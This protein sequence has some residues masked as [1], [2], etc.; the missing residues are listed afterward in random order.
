VG[1]DY[2]LVNSSFEWFPGV[3]LYHS[4]DLVHWKQIGAVL[5]RPSNL[6]L[7]GVECSGGIYAPTLRYHDGVFYMITTLNGSHA[8]SGNFIVTAQRPEG[9]WSDPHWIAGAEGIDPS[10]FFDDD[11]RAYYCGNGRPEHL[12]SEKHR[13]IW[14]RELDLKTWSLVGPRGVLDSAEYF[15]SG[16]LGPVNNFEGPHLYKKDGH[17]YLML[18]HGGTSKNHAISIWRGDHPLGPFTVADPANPIV[19]HRG[20]HP[21]GLT[22]TGHGDLLQDARG[23]WWMALLGVR[24]DTGKTNMGRETFLVPVSWSGD[25]PVVN[26]DGVRSRVELREPA[27]RLPQ[28]SGDTESIHETFAGPELSPAWT[29]IRT[30]R[31]VWWELGQKPGWLTLQLRPEKITDICNPSFIG[32]RQPESTMTAST[33]VDVAP[34]GPAECAGMALLRARDAVF[35]FVVEGSDNGR[36]V[37]VYENGK[38]VASAT[39]GEGLVNLQIRVDG[40]AETFDYRVADASA[41][42]LIRLNEPILEMSAGGRFTGTFVGLYASSRGAASTTRAGFHGFDLTAP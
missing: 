38:R 41:S 14:I 2:Y 19:T 21:A 10:L 9:P 1:D 16:K 28:S 7:D 6:N 5:S 31:S 8:K 26:P 4:R 29:F 37:A 32:V 25:W 33:Q 35:E 23:D 34:K 3:P 36:S 27:P 22:C 39:I 11:G 17:Y 42:T 40:P 20:D 15:A 18:S 30:P 24:S 13:L 12:V